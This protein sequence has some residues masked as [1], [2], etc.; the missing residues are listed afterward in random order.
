MGLPPDGGLPWLSLLALAVL[1]LGG[2]GAA[3]VLLYRIIT[4]DGP[5]VAAG[6]AYLLPVVAL[7]LGALLL[8][9]TVGAASVAGVVLVLLGVALT[10][11][12]SR[13]RTAPDPRPAPGA[14]AAPRHDGT[15]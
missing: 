6:V 11:R 1:G 9:E 7:L 13:R 8:D 4:D 14:V 10:R 2:T 3:Y 5:V 15:P 12:R